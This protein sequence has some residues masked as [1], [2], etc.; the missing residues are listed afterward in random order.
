METDSPFCQKPCPYYF[1]NMIKVKSTDDLGRSI[2][3]IFT[4][5]EEGREQAKHY[6]MDMIKIGNNINAFLYLG[7]D[8]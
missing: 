2:E 5:T 3:V 4:D 1:K 8:E 7:E 6:M